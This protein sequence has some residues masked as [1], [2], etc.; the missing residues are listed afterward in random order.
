VRTVASLRMLTQLSFRPAS[1]EPT[2]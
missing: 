2:A 1:P